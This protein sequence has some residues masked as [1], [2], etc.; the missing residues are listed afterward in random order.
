MGTAKELL[1]RNSNNI[2]TAMAGM[3][4]ITT[5]FMAV[6]ATPRALEILDSLPED[7]TK[8]DKAKAVAPVYIPSAAMGGLT[9]TCIFG[10]NYVNVKR[11]AAI[12]GLYSLSE[13]A[14]KEY[15]EKVVETIGEK[16]E[17]II[18]EEIAQKH[19]DENPVKDNEVIITN[20]GDSLCYDEIS[21][22][23][24]MSNIEQ[25]RHVE[26]DMNARIIDEVFVSLNEFYYYLGLSPLK[27]GD[28]IGWNVERML[29][30][31]FTSKIADD[32]RPCLI[33]GYCDAPTL[34]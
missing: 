9:L 19:I 34:R 25:I 11:N 24:F 33:I 10:S 13:K 18:K 20:Y 28:D 4:V 26:N 21:G 14:F 22:R 16:K 7:A 5:T 6:K 30:L 27:Y 3:G 23:Y 15:Q 8:L 29:R 32:G 12:V 17:N 31:R 2:L 1:I